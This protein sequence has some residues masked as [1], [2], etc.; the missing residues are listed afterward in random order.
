MLLKPT[1]AIPIT[2]MNF[3]IPVE[4]D[5]PGV[6]QHDD[7]FMIGRTKEDQNYCKQSREG[8]RTIIKVIPENYNN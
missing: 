6:F 5:Y 7:C 2:Q 1:V 4:F 3:I 8:G